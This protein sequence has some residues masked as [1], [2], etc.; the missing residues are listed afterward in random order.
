MSN[1]PG[2]ASTARTLAYRADS[3]RVIQW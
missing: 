2:L 1:F 3:Y